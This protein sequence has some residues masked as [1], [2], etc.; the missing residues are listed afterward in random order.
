[1]VSRVHIASAVYWSGVDL[2]ICLLQGFNAVLRIIQFL[3]SNLMAILVI[4]LSACVRVQT[5]LLLFI[6]IIFA[7][8]RL[9]LYLYTPQST[10][11]IHQCTARPDLLGH[12]EDSQTNSAL[13]PLCVPHLSW[14]LH[15]PLLTIFFIPASPWG[16]M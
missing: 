10:T 13:S 2:R 14:M 8:R 16:R 1:M 6:I 11:Q 4:S 7:N 3:K 5:A 9:D 15:K 12:S